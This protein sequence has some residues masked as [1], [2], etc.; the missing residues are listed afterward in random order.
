M[1][2]TGRAPGFLTKSELQEF[3]TGTAAHAYRTFGCHALPG[4][5][6]HRFAVW[7]PHAQRVALVGDFNGWDTAATRWTPAARTA[8]MGAR[9][10]TGCTDGAL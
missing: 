1:N 7:A 8:P 10:W 4:T 9:P 5:T 3:H 6:G 2:T